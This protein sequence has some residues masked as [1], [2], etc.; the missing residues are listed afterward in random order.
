MS[1]VRVSVPLIDLAAQ[2]RALKPEIDRAIQRVLDSG[3]FIL[4]PEVESLEREVAAYCGTKYAVG[5][6]SGTD[7]LELSL[8]A[9]GVGTGDEVL[10]TAYSFI[11]TAEAIVAVGARPVFVDIDPVSYALD[12]AAIE[13]LVTKR[14]KAVIPVH[15]YGHPCGMDA[16]VRVARRHRL[17]VI[18]DCAQAIGARYRG[19]RVGSFGTAGALSFYPSKNLGGYG[20]GGMVVTNDKRV[21]EQVR[22]LRVHGSGERYRHATLGTNSRLDELQAAILRVKLRH[23]DRW[24]SARREHALRYRRAFAR[25]GLLG[26]VQLPQERSG[27]EHVYHLYTVRVA[28][29][30]RLQA[31]L[32]QQGIASQVAYPIPLPAQPALAAYRRSGQAFPHAARA[33]R[34]VLSLPMYPELSPQA[35]ETVVEAM[36][37][38]VG[39]GSRRI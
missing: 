23:L 21:A 6:A 39:S 1:S 7:A 30:G 28:G 3:Q 19:R 13:P 34:E 20:D 11:A 2:Y 5:V 36:A 10:T 35:I 37:E 14:T 8:R 24:T 4:G 22:L 29:R 9:C 33:A 38:A 32:E 18:E 12:P 16:V 25:R 26:R 27:C 17:A 31:T 15:L